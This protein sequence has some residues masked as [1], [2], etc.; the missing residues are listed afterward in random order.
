M[1][2]RIMT[3]LCAVMFTFWFDNASMAQDFTVSIPNTAKSQGYLAPL[4]SGSSVDF[5]IEVICNVADTFKVSIDKYASFPGCADWFTFEAES[6]TLSKGQTATFR[7]AVRPPAGSKDATYS[8]VTYFNAI[9]RSSNNHPF[10]GGGTLRLIVDNT[11]PEIL[12][13]RPLSKTSTTVSFEWDC[14]DSRSLEYTNAT[15][16]TVG[17]NGVKSY[18]VVLRNQNGA[19]VGRWSADATFSNNLHT[20]TVQPNTVYTPVVSAVDLAGNSSSKAGA[21]VTTPPAAPTNLA[22]TGTD[23]CSTTLTWDASAGATRYHVYNATKSPATEIGTTSGTSYRVAGLS[24][25]APSNYYVTAEGAGGVSPGSSVLSVTTLVVP[26]PIISGPAVVC[27]SGATYTVVCKVTNLPEGCSVSWGKDP[28][29]NLVSASG[30]TATFSCVEKGERSVTASIVSCGGASEVL[31]RAITFGIPTI[32]GIHFISA[33]GDDGFWCDCN[34]GNM[35]TIYS[36]FGTNNSNY[37]I[38][39]LNSTWTKNLG[40]QTSGSAGMAPSFSHIPGF[41]RFRARVV[42]DC[43]VGVWFDSSIDVKDCSGGGGHEEYSI[44]PNF[45]VIV[46]A[47]TTLSPN[48]ASTIVAVNIANT[49]VGEG[50]F[51]STV[52]IYNT[53][54]QLVKEVIVEG[55]E[56]SFSVADLS[57]GMYVVH[58]ISGGTTYKQKLQIVR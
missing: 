27:S 47:C 23:Y 15:N 44:R 14:I 25:G 18:G 54:G 45:G 31:S 32:T 22:A 10:Y 17:V 6:F 7:V 51:F 56:S 11:P 46:N 34:S 48:P 49:N 42:S 24:A 41:Y 29:L 36:D 52:R 58:V 1:K 50:D 8:F 39:V 16:Q 13:I 38:Q 53:L 43:G 4:K 35:Y 40:N 55:C 21:A 20:F 57:E 33:K 30:N 37:E 12:A 19:E 2:N 3:I 26:K 5:R 9:D 28:K